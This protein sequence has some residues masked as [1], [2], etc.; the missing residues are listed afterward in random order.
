MVFWDATC[1]TGKDFD[2]HQF[3]QASSSSCAKAPTCSREDIYKADI[4][5]RLL[6]KIQ[7]FITLRIISAS[8]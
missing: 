2:K 5:D 6:I 1:S 4:K 8:L 7:P 3:F